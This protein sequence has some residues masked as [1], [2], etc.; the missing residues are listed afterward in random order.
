M[1]LE[2]RKM[3]DLRNKILNEELEDDIVTEPSGPAEE[4]QDTERELVK[5]SILLSIKKM[6]GILPEMTEFDVDVIVL[7]NS[8]LNALTEIGVGPENGFRITGQDEKWVDFVGEETLLNM[9]QP[10]VFL[11]TKIV[12]DNSSSTAAMLQAYKDEIAELAYRINTW[13]ELLDK[14]PVPIDEWRKS[15]GIPEF[16][17]GEEEDELSW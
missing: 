10:Y 6:L 3:S 14:E 8:S 13:V 4:E 16:E 5:E 9:V 12:F 11:R 2:V 15:M 17:G 1:S 7:I